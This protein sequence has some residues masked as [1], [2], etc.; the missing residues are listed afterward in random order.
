MGRITTAMVLL[1]TGIAG[2]YDGI[3]TDDPD[4]DDRASKALIAEVRTLAAGRGIERLEPAPTVRPEL[5]E[6]GRALAF[7]KELSGNRD[8][9][10]MTCHLPELATGDARSLSIGQGATGLGV[11]RAHP[12]GVFIPRNAPPL[13][14][15]HAMDQLFWDGRVREGPNGVVTPAGAHVTGEMQ[16][17]FE[18]G[19]IS[20]LPLFPVMSREEMRG[21]PGANE[22]AAYANAD[23]TSVWAALMV[24]L[25]DIPEY[26]E[27]FE[28]AYPGT[29]FA[30]MTFA[31]A[32]NAI[33][34]FLVSELS[35]TETPWDQFLDGDDDALTQSQL[36]GA[37]NF[38]SA[39][40]S[41]CHGGD[42]LTD[43][44]F[45]N[46]ALAQF[47]PGQAQGLAGRDDFGR[48]NV[49]GDPADR[50][51]FRS[52]PLRNVELTAP[53]GHA[54]QFVELFDFIDHYSE[55]ATKLQDYDESQ[56]EPA[57]AAT[58][59][60]NVA[61]VLAL[62]DPLLEGVVFPKIVVLDVTTFMT[63]LTDDDA[64]DL[65]SIAPAS[66]PSDLPIDAL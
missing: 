60:D 39:R 54:G 37:K 3:G 40:C 24:R 43:L 10:C 21:A 19:A 25:G 59:I 63:A 28:A 66:V 5:V 61:D 32:S 36:R 29:D 55:S 15:L 4:V 30:D 51:R 12:D 7:D 13:F 42:A 44:D 18:F 41:I 20:A 8:I 53:Y 48:E 49:T 65:S 58:V 47:G 23:F 14:N 62:R 50:Y 38:L 31:H 45:H 22:L 26:V 52:T 1:A 34:G 33:G 9:S 2:C 6:L 11:V 46:V 16:D 17:V 64:R 56:L 35:F 27:M 57:L